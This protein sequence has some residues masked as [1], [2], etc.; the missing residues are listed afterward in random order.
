MTK[1]KQIKPQKRVT[2]TTSA[3]AKPMGVGMGM[4]RIGNLGKYAHKPKGKR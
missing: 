1:I 3:P 4:S 2:V